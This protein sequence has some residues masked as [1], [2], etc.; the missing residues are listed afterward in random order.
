MKNLVDSVRELIEHC[1]IAND[2]YAVG[3]YR[4]MFRH[5]TDLNKLDWNFADRI[6]DGVNMGNKNA[7]EDYKNYIRYVESFSPEN[8][9]YYKD[10]LEQIIKEND[11]N[12]ELDL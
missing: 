6:L 7:I 2:Q 3:L 10:S 8:A 5:E 4:A 11:L 9:K 1:D 12:E